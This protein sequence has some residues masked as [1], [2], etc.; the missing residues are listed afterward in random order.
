MTARLTLCPEGSP[1]VSEPTSRG[2]VDSRALPES[3]PSQLHY[4][5]LARA[6]VQARVELTDI[7]LP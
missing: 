1:Q 6:V 4:Y 3:I 2:L 7:P 5:E